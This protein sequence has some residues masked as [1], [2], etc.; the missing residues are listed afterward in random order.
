MTK[1]PSLPSDPSLHPH[2]TK[3]TAATINPFLTG[4]TILFF[5]QV[6][7]SCK[8]RSKDSDNGG[9]SSR[10]AGG[11]EP[12]PSRVQRKKPIW[13]RSRERVRIEEDGRDI[14]KEVAAMNEAKLVGGMI[15]PDIIWED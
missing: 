8:K 6:K 14:E 9:K 1:N 7:E 15:A 5:Q 10:F 13:E 11:L 12:L 2:N 3:I 4:S